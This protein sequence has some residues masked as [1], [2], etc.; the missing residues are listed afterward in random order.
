MNKK[1]TL[2]CSICSSR[3]YTTN[4]NISTNLNRLEVNKFC[5]RCEK[6]TLHQ[7]TK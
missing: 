5:K 1:I 4:K 2:A 3:N 6:H 7:E